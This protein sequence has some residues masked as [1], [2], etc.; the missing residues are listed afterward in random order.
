MKIAFATDLHIK[1]SPPSSRLDKET[2]LDSLI[3]KINFIIDYSNNNAD[4]LIF[5]GDIFDKPDTVYSLTIT[6]LKELKKV[7]I[8][9]YTII[10]NHDI[11]GYQEN[12]INKSS[13]GVLLES[14]VI[15]K[16][17]TLEFNDLIIKGMHCYSNN[18]FN[19]AIPG[20]NNILICHKPITNLSIPNG[21]NIK[22]ISNNCNYNMVLSGDIHIGHIEKENNILFLNPGAIL[23]ASIVEKDRTPQM[24]IIDTKDN[25]YKFVEIPHQKNVFDEQNQK[26]IDVISPNFMDIFVTNIYDIKKSSKTIEEILINYLQENNIDKKIIENIKYYL[27]T[28]AEEGLDD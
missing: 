27:Q 21:I 6:I 9:M 10:G 25:S 23:R 5:G 1:Y 17:D 11:Y 12:S 24:V 26:I 13:I 7:Q 19:D 22:K 16:L 15:Q 2:F 4:I 8:P 3:R 18:I 14:E 28:S 20:K